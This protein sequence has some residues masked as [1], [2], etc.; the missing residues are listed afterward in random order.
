MGVNGFDGINDI[1]I[2][3]CVHLEVYEGCSV[4]DLSSGNQSFS[5]LFFSLSSVCERV[6]DICMV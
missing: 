2:D 5:L 1:L 3:G 4:C 6:L